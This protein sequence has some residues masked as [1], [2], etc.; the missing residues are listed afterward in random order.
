MAGFSW[1]R[2]LASSWEKM[3]GVEFTKPGHKY[4]VTTVMTIAN[5]MHHRKNGSSIISAATRS[6]ISIAVNGLKNGINVLSRLPG[7]ELLIL[8]SSGMM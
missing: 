7:F 8:Y 4:A 5:L 6:W 2:I 1:C 3:V